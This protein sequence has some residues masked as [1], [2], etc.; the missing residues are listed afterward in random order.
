MKYCNLILFVLVVTNLYTASAKCVRCEEV[1]DLFNIINKKLDTIIENEPIPP[2]P[3]VCKSLNIAALNSK[4]SAKL[5][6]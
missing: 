5:V 6:I 4:E 2:P 3:P 1:M